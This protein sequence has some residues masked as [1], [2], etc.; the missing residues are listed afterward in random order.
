METKEKVSYEEAA[1][2]A[3][4]LEECL[5]ESVVRLIFKQ[6]RGPNERVSEGSAELFHSSKCTEALN[7]LETDGFTYG[8]RPSEEMCRK[9][10]QRL[11]YSFDGN[12]AIVD[13]EVHDAQYCISIFR[14]NMETTR[15]QFLL[16]PFNEFGNH[17]RDFYHGNLRLDELRMIDPAQQDYET[18]QRFTSLPVTLQKVC[19]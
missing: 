4:K 8:P 3:G 11:L 16:K 5:S 7:C 13:E 10:G 2:N 14:K 6:R 1:R 12:V 15:R 18:G 19:R 17:S 9:E